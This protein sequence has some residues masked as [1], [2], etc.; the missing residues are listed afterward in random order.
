M[1]R[2]LGHHRARSAPLPP[3]PALMVMSMVMPLVQLVVLGYAFGGQ[4]QES[5]Y[6]RR[7]PGPRRAGGQAPGDVPGGGGQR[8]HLRHP[9]LHRRG[10]ALRDL[11]EGRIDGVLNIP[12]DFSREVLA[13]AGPPHGADRGQ[14]RPVLRRLR[15]L[16]GVVPPCSRPSGRKPSGRGCRR[17]VARDRRGLSVRSLHPVPAAGDHR[18][19]DLRLGHDRRRH[20]LHRRQ[21]PRPARG[22]PRDA[23]HEV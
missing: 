22:I 9:A 11:R 6:R 12:P 19:R 23:D 14:H 7:R 16:E 3:Q 13:G 1:I 8:P 20:H 10:A 15:R 2:D 21:G 18:A 4:N 5:R 17:R